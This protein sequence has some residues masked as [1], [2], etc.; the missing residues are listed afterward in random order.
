MKRREFAVR[1]GGMAWRALALCAV[2][3][4]SDPSAAEDLSRQHEALLDSQLA[5]IE[6]STQGKPESYLLGAGLN[7][8]Q[9][10]FKNDVESIRDLFDKHWNT[11]RRSVALIADEST[12]TAYAYPSRAF[13]RRAASSIGQKMDRNKDVFMVFLSSH[14]TSE[15]LLAALPDGSKFSF[16]AVDVRK[17]LEESGAKYRVVVIS[18]CHSGA[19]M[20]ELQDDRTLVMA[21]AHADRTS[22]GCSFSQLH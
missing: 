9:D 12:K 20:K 14:G 11:A 18:A 7:N 3:L 6:K 21:A 19:L 1:V 15:G 22:F 13:L 2:F 8:R 10:V 5:G 4:F 17:L 16:T